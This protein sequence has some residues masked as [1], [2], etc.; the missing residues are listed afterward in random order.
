MGSTF[1]TSDYTTKLQSS[2]PYWHKKRNTDKCNKTES[3]EVIPCTYGFLIF[4]KGGKNIQWGK[5]SLFSK[6]CWENCSATCKTMKLEHILKPYTKISLKMDKDL[7]VR[8]ETIKLLEEN[9]GRTL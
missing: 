6:C 3:S 9:T 7:N 4:H 2:R 1:L 5:D 8:P